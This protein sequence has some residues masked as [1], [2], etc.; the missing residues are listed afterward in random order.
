MAAA[1]LGRGARARVVDQDPAHEQA[2]DGEEVATI[3]EARALLAGEL[4]EDLVDDGGRLEGVA[5][6][7]AAHRPLGDP[8]QL[9]VE[10]AEDPVEGR[11]VARAP[12][13]EQRGDLA[14]VAG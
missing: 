1:A 11:A 10:L 3:A 4:E 5:G 14:R 9:G 13:V 7:L 12:G 8:L 6:A 2:G